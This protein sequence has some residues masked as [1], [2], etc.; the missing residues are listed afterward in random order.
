MS[1]V[2]KYNFRNSS[3]AVK[4]LELYLNS[5]KANEVYVKVN[6]GK[7]TVKVRGDRLLSKSYVAEAKKAVGVV[8]SAGG[9][10]KLLNTVDLSVLFRSI[11][12][13]SPIPADSIRLTLIMMGYRAELNGPKLMTNA[14]TDTIINVI[15]R[16]GEAYDLLKEYNMSSGAKRLVASYAV[17]KGVKLDD[18]IDHLKEVGVLN[19]VEVDGEEH[20]TLKTNIDEALDLVLSNEGQRLRENES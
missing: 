4:F 13:K 17:A 15:Q 3:D 6:G 19:S 12:V 8:K 5:I 10:N 1:K 16:L 2:I 7:V 11:K 18:A 14:P 20:L 9:G